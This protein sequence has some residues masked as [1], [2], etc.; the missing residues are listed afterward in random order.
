MSRTATETRPRAAASSPSSLN[1]PALQFPRVE[2]VAMN[3]H[4]PSVPCRL[5]RVLVR[6]HGRLPDAFRHGALRTCSRWL[7]MPNSL[8]MR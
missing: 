5:S 7:L 6:M 1:S 2:C 4:T 8:L 3:S